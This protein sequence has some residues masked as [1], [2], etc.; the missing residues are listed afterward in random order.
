VGRRGQKQHGVDVVGKDNNKEWVGIQCKWKKYGNKL[1]EKEI[2]KEI[3]KA[4]QFNPPLDHF[5]ILTTAQKDAVLEKM[6]REITEQHKE[7]ELFSVSIW[8]WEDITLKI[9]NF[10]NL[11]NKYLYNNRIEGVFN[12]KNKFEI[13]GGNNNIEIYQQNV[14]VY[15]ADSTALDDEFKS[16][17]DYSSQLINNQYKPVEAFNYLEGL[18]K[19]IWDKASDKNKYRILTNM[20]AAKLKMQEFK[21]G[22]YLIIEA[23]QYYKESENALT[24]MALAYS[25]LKEK[26]KVKSLIDKVLERNPINPNAYSLKIDLMYE[27]G[28]GIDEIIKQIPEHLIDKK[29]IAKSLAQK[30]F[31][32][33][34]YK[35]A[36]SYLNRINKTD[37]DPFTYDMLAICIIQ[38]I[39]MKSRPLINDPIEDSDKKR[40]NN[41]IKLLNEVWKKYENSELTERKAACLCDLGIAEALL[42]NKEKAEDYFRQAIYE[43]PED[44]NVKKN[45]GLFYLKNDIYEKAIKYLIDISEIEGYSFANVSIG[46]AYA[47][48][49]QFEKSE[50]FLKKILTSK[51]INETERTNALILLADNYLSEKK[52]EDAKSL[53]PN[54]PNSVI[55]NFISSKILAAQNQEDQAVEKLKMAKIE[56]E[57]YPTDY[58]RLQIG[59]EFYHYK[60]YREATDLFEILAD[61]NINSEITQ[62][63]LLCYYYEERLE[64]ALAIAE[65]LRLKYGPL[66]LVTEIEINIME[67]IGDLQATEKL[68]E[69]F[70]N[71]FP[72]HKKT[73]IHFA[74]LKLRLNKMN[75]AQKV[76]ADLVESVNFE[77]F[78]KDEIINT[79]MLLDNTGRFH[80]AV[81]LVYNSLNKYSNDKDMCEQYMSLIIFNKKN[82]NDFQPEQVEVDC[83]VKIKD[84]NGGIHWKIIENDNPDFSKS[85]IHSSNPLA[86]EL[87]GEKIGSKILF[88]DSDLQPEYGN[89]EEIKHK[90]VYRLHEILRTYEQNFP[91]SKA[92]QSINVDVTTPKPDKN[93]KGFDVIFKMLDE[94]EKRHNEIIQS[95]QTGIMPIGFLSSLLGGSSVKTFLGLISN[96]KTPIHSCYGSYKERDMA[97]SSLTSDLVLIG[98]IT[99]IVT[100]SILG[101]WALVIEQFGKIRIVQETKDEI[102]GFLKTEERT[103][104][105]ISIFKD[106]DDYC[107]VETEEQRSFNLKFLHKL[108]DSV[109]QYCDVIPCKKYLSVDPKKKKEI[110]DSLGVSFYKTLLIVSDTKDAIHYSDDKVLRDLGLGEYKNSGIWTQAL[111]MYLRKEGK[112]SFED[113]SSH[114]IELAKMKFE[115][116]T[117]N[118]DIMLKAAQESDWSAKP[119]FT[120][121]CEMLSGKLSDD[122]SIQITVDFLLKL[123][124][125]PI[126]SNFFKNNLSN[127]VIEEL[128]KGRDRSRALKK[129]VQII[130]EKFHGYPFYK[131][132]IKKTITAWKKTHM[133]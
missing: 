48:L 75:E 115:F 1:T 6:V 71:K 24:N 9:G 80:D 10:E 84:E 92:F 53:I 45:I 91:E 23:S 79:A 118:I 4:I 2:S 106:K 96:P 25:I 110:E 78:K 46:F 126:I 69:T 8:G 60:E 15:S 111:L 98:D 89:I 29:E 34:K 109:E 33:K 65:N 31:N 99:S 123:W 13:S 20:G 18:K 93:T 88:K 107:Y 97:F 102:Y 3:E 16:E 63:L 32:A 132:E 35:E 101:I 64:K 121:I 37:H 59:I 94:N 95:Y 39:L 55:E 11:K 67:I 130:N 47:E 26:D 108:V 50:K 19:R 76:V 133:I 112:L 104:S 62:R 52:W 113:Y 42:D 114:S 70:I 73:I 38:G 44:P 105:K 72:G 57:K 103:D 127:I 119:P 87:I 86:K 5:F 128:L 27:N 40:L 14:M 43:S 81:K 116:T 54:C 124:E 85:E 7:K 117:I 61:K 51:E 21:A 131:N 17:I 49:G 66:K 77:K 41:A 30:A 74:Q 12:S 56:L 120:T 100:M 125:I 122:S 58:L 129:L 36:E 22:A 28:M 82:E 90:Y 68:L 83:A